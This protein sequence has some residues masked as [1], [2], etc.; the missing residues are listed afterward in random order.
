MDDWRA[1][2]SGRTARRWRA[3]GCCCWPGRPGTICPAAAKGGDDPF[4]L[5]QL[6]PKTRRGPPQVAETHAQH[7]QHRQMLG[8][9]AVHAAN[10][11]IEFEQ[12]VDRHPKQ[13][14]VFASFHPRFARGRS[15][16][17]V[18]WL[19]P[20]STCRTAPPACLSA[21]RHTHRAIRPRAARAPPHSVRRVQNGTS[22]RRVRR[23]R[24]PE[25]RSAA[26]NCGD[27][28][29]ALSDV[30]WIMCGVTEA[31]RSAGTTARRPWHAAKPSFQVRCRA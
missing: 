14:R 11:A 29:R 1:R 25:A 26:N 21:G 18:W 10:G 15:T 20:R 30:G 4:A 13:R 12:Q 22:R 23:L 27:M 6:Q 7:E 19:R 2:R 16:A 17:V 5:S 8:G 31:T 9:D 24:Q 3:N 28:L